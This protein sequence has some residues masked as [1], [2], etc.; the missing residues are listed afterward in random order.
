MRGKSV[1]QLPGLRLLGYFEDMAMSASNNGDGEQSIL[2]ETNGSEE[3]SPALKAC[4]RYK[5]EWF[6]KTIRKWKADG[7]IG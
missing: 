5:A 1:S 2:F 3:I 4:E 7:V 6:E